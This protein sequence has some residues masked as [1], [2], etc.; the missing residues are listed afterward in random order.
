[1]AT[2]RPY[3]FVDKARTLLDN[4]HVADVCFIVGDKQTPIY[5]NRNILAIGSDVFKQ[6]FY[7]PLK[8]SNFQIFIPDCS[9]TGLMNVLRYLSTNF[10]QPF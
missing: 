1:M 10:N 8:D 5:A 4:Q 7:G 9:P 3:S 6:M 2:T